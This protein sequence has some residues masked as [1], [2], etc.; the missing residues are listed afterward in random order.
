MRTRLTSRPLVFVSMLMSLPLMALACAGGGGDEGEGEGEGECDVD[1][2]SD[3]PTV[4]AITAGATSIVC[5]YAQPSEGY[6]RKI[7]ASAE[8]D[9]FYAGGN[10]KGAIGCADAVILTDAECP[11][12]NAVG[13]CD[14]TNIEAER[15][16]YS[17]SKFDDPSANCDAVG[18]TYSAL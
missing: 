12:E 13:R 1:N 4:D 17:C 15:L 2:V 11:T 16:Y 7:T 18:G 10:D 8:I 5:Y 14:A 9:N 6:C 3:G